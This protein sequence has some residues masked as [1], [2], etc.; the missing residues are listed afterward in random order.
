[1]GREMQKV[2]PALLSLL[3]RAYGKKVST[4]GVVLTA[5]DA[6]SARETY[7]PPSIQNGLHPPGREWAAVLRML[8]NTDRQYESLGTR[9]QSFNIPPGIE[10]AYKVSTTT[11]SRFRG[12]VC[13]DAALV[14]VEFV[15]DAGLVLSVE[16]ERD[17]DLAGVI[18]KAITRQLAAHGYIET[19]WVS[20]LSGQYFLILLGRLMG[21]DEREDYGAL[22]DTFLASFN[23]R[24]D[25]TLV[26]NERNVLV[27]PDELSRMKQC[28]LDEDAADAYYSRT[29]RT[30]AE[31]IDPDLLHKNYLYGLIIG[32]A[33][34]RA[35]RT[36]H[37]VHDIA[38]EHLSKRAGPALDPAGGWVP[39]RIPWITARV[40]LSLRELHDEVLTPELRKIISR[41]C[42]SL[43]ARV[44][45]D[46]TWRS[47]VGS[48]VSL[49]ESTGLCLEALL[50]W[51]EYCD[52]TSLD[53]SLMAVWT[54]RDE[55][56]KTPDL[57]SEDGANATLAA[58][59]LCTNLLKA[60]PT[61]ITIQACTRYLA[62]VL[63]H[64]EA[65]AAPTTRQYCTVPQIL[66]Y[67]AKG[68]R[69][70]DDA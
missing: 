29:A 26:L 24:A 19:E 34:Q 68:A 42:Y 50:A 1:M 15:Y 66:Y 45:P 47:G 21:D 30:R 63:I 70:Q 57:T 62:E 20:A 55:W 33:A 10:A 23:P 60:P 59:V 11:S 39:Y 36:M 37:N 61:E 40:L 32:I 14:F 8:F 67:A 4:R 12:L 9:R 53:D 13:R 58:T 16:L 52:T 49:W 65:V 27:T 2:A 5:I 64:A 28:M 56:L 44:L 48:W 69:D 54:R 17:Q 6:L 46:G 41:A 18:G 35:G 25:D 3:H 38:L 7:A 51:P 22:L 43:L 31:N